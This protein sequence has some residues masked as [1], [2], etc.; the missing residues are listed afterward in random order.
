[1][2]QKKSRFFRVFVWG[3]FSVLMMVTHVT[4]QGMLTPE[5]IPQPVPETVQETPRTPLFSGN[6]E[7]E[8][9]VETPVQDASA[10]PFLSVGM[11]KM[12]F[13]LA[14]VTLLFLVLL[15]ILKK[16]SPGGVPE[17][18]REVFEVLGKSAFVARQQVYLLRCGEKLFLVSVS[19][20]GL[21]RVGE[22]DDP[23]EVER[24]TRRCRGEILGTTTPV[25][26]PVA[27]GNS[28][29]ELTGKEA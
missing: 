17:L 19:Q 7:N 13:A 3:L 2:N 12:L 29:S 21:D 24:L 22:I 8:P 26:I 15:I 27:S 28:T 20:N 5:A 23:A 18:P 1:M 10:T 4:A 9:T 11:Q 25:G 14:S 6:V 16:F